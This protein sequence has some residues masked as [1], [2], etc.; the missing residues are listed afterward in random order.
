MED[1]EIES[2]RR[3]YCYILIDYLEL[4]RSKK[5]MNASFMISNQLFKKGNGKR[6]NV[7]TSAPA[8]MILNL[9]YILL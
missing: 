4:N 5:N 7:Q 9:S 2:N 1:Y 6:L 8:N 3:V